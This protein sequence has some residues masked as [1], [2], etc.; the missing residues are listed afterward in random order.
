MGSYIILFIVKI[1]NMNIVFEDIFF[2]GGV[3]INDQ[4]NNVILFFYYWFDFG[5]I[6]C[7]QKREEGFIY[8]LSLSIYNVYNCINFYFICIELMF[9]FSW[10][11]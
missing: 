4:C 2:F 5:C 11:G 9:C 7:W 8:D 3:C 1:F 6:Y 10:D